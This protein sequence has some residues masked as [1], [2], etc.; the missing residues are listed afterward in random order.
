MR[1]RRRRLTGS[2][3]SFAGSSTYPVELNL[4]V[5]RAL[6]LLTGEQRETVVLKVY[7]GF[8]FHEIAD[9]LGCPASTIKSRL[10][11]AFEVLRG[12]DCPASGADGPELELRKT[13][14]WP[15]CQTHPTIYEITF[16]AS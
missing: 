10:Y 16:L 5:R 8:K 9:I 2:A 1:K 3:I 14:R 15:L 12:C 6:E 13:K 7:H 4:A 11:S